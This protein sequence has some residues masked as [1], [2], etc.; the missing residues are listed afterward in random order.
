MSAAKRA[1]FILAAFALPGT[2]LAA[3]TTPTAP[4][5]PAA[6]VGEA[7]PQA[8]VNAFIAAINR[9]DS[10]AMGR[11]FADGATVFFPGPPFPIRRIQG[12]AEVMRYFGRLF[13]AL[14][15]RGVRQGNTA[16]ADLVFQTW[17]DTSIATFH[18]NGGQDVGRRTLVLRRIGGRWLISHLHASAYRAPAPAPAAATPARP[19]PQPQQPPRPPGR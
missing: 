4:T 8:A 2:A 10:V 19:A 6:Q 7:S 13:E 5:A 12:K 16:P 3:P 9:L 17:D 18:L 14:R 1:L 15:A 11:L